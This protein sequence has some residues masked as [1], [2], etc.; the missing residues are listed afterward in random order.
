MRAL[1]RSPLWWTLALLMA[2]ASAGAEE[3]VSNKHDFG[4]MTCHATHR[5]KGP[6]L[7]RAEVTPKTEKGTPLVGSAG[8]CYSC[9]KTE[10]K[11]GQFFEPGVSHPVNV[12][13]PPGM[14]I[15]KELGTTLVKGLG[16]VITCVTCHDPHSK[17]PGFLKLPMQGDKLCVACHKF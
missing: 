7:F 2:A 17:K 1:G 6:S 14:V 4:C 9:H 16:E 10:E 3:A 8:T 12:P 11:G 13:P 5:P 15:P